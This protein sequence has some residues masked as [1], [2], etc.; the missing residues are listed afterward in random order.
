MN[1]G[2][3]NLRMAT[4][5]LRA[6]HL[7]EEDARSANANLRAKLLANSRAQGG[8]EEW[9]SMFAASDK[10]HN[11]HMDTAESSSGVYTALIEDLKKSVEDGFINKVVGSKLATLLFT[12]HELRKEEV[13]CTDASPGNNCIL[14]FN[15]LTVKNS[16]K[17]R[18]DIANL[19]KIEDEYH[20]KTLD[21]Q[22]QWSVACV[23]QL[24]AAI[25]MVIEHTGRVH[26]AGAKTREH[27]H[28]ES[29][30]GMQYDAKAFAS[31]RGGMTA[32][33]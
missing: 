3:V 33:V 29:V 26:K 31:N 23:Y 18:E 16:E 13:V 17:F 20:G 7:L 9:K 22:K 6:C 11:A 2:T 4:A 5:V 27:E 24:F 15:A 21:E 8:D 25:G 12:L 28:L 1:A 30:G 10:V 32:G 14:G 19:L